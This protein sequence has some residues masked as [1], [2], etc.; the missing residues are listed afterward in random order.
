MIHEEA[1]VRH[2]HDNLVEVE[3][4]RSKPCGLCGQTQGCGNGI[5]GKIF[6][7]KKGLLTFKNTIDASVGDRVYLAIE[8]NYLLKTAL[9]IYGIPLFALFFGMISTDI[10]VSHSS[11]LKSFVGGVF[12]F[13][14]GVFSVKYISVKN[15]DHL[16]QDAILLKTRTS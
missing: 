1:L 15:H 4:V 9:I 7:Q 6:S 3:I 13:V 14:L 11:D 2:T 16:Y 12:G 10:L 8:E 5:W